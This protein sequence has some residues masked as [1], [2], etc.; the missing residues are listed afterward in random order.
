MCNCVYITDVRC[1]IVLVWQLSD[2]YLRHYG[3]RAIYDFVGMTAVR[4]VI[5]SQWQLIDM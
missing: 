3:S 2:K 1:I 5:V 4:Y